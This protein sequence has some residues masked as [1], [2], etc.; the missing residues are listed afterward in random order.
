MDPWHPWGI[1]YARHPELTRKINLPLNARVSTV[2]NGS[3]WNIPFGRGWDRQV[4]AFSQKCREITIRNGEDSWVW[5]PDKGFSIKSAIN[6][7]ASYGP[8]PGWVKI[9]WCIHHVPRY[10]IILWLACWKRL[11]TQDKLLKWGMISANHC[12]LCEQSLE[13][14]DHIFFRCSYSKKVWHS[15]LSRCMHYP[16]SMD[17]DSTLAWLETNQ[18]WKSKLQK[19]LVTFCFSVTVYTIWHERNR[20]FFQ[21]I[22]RNENTV[23]SE[24]LEKVRFATH[25]W[26]GY[27]RS[28]VNWELVME[29][30]IPHNIL[31]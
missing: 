16:L 3:R 4:L 27:K 21:Q 17:W 12:L 8:A 10:A 23:V 24:I 19:N 7:L 18:S 29:M 31:D 26:K 5:N 28:K 11:N 9:V 20:R 13:D 6:A 22:K 15:I 1:L 30:G 25:A 14:Q 2:L